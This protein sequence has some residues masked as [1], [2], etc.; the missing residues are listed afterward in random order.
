MKSISE[1]ELNRAFL[2]RQY[3]LEP[4]DLPPLDIIENL[5]AVQAQEA[6]PPYTALW[7]RSKDFSRKQLTD[8]LT[9]RS[10][11]RASGFR[12]TI[13]IISTRDYAS[14]Y[15]IQHASIVRKLQGYLEHHPDPSG[16]LA[17][18]RNA[19][20]DKTS[21]YTGPEMRAALDKAVPGYPADKWRGATVRMALAGVRIP[22]KGPESDGPR[23]YWL[24]VE[25]YLG[26]DLPATG[27]V[28]ELVRRYLKGYGP[29]SVKDAQ[30]FLGLT[31]LHEVFARLKPE[32]LSF[33]TEGGATV[34]DL[35]HSLRPSGDI[36][37]P[38]KMVAAYDHLIL[39]HADRS[40]VIQEKYRLPVAKVNAIFS[41]V[42]TVNG[43][44]S[45]MWNFTLSKSGEATVRFTLFEHVNDEFM[46]A[47]YREAQRYMNH[48]SSG[49]SQSIEVDRWQFN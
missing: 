33:K 47:L 14:F 43:K 49:A 6:E 29:A 9:D 27:D 11:V 18:T 24:S 13:H 32:L 37:A 30:S 1:L 22:R 16:W 25:N 31:R 15:P 39:G 36:P 12:Q 8:L 35:P 46:D 20:L 2:A 21:G 3:L 28:D 5:L 26:R 4:T 23:D 7:A 19:L 17:D 34:F 40:R 38:V 41:P 45:G 10:A 42:F 44:V 48:R